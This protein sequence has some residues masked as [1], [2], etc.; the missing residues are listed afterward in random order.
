MLEME[1]QE[2]NKM[3]LAKSERISLLPG[4]GTSN[5]WPHFSKVTVDN[6]FLQHVVCTSCK[7]VLKWKSK[8]DTSGLKAQL[9]ACKPGSSRKM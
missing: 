8:E 1:K 3:L 4:E 9:Q 5:M 7:T 6:L 2:L